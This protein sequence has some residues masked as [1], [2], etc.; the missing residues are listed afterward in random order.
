MTPL[1]WSEDKP[2]CEGLWFW[3]YKKGEAESIVSVVS[4]FGVLKID[5]HVNP[6]SKLPGQ[7]SGPIPLPI[8]PDLPHYIDRA[9]STDLNER[10]KQ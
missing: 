1:I 9:V 4:V 7:W 10:V 5:G 2:S 3:R 8:E 6:C